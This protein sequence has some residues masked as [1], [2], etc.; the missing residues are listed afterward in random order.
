MSVVEAPVEMIEAVADLR[1]PPQADARLQLRKDRNTEG[2]LSEAEPVRA[3]GAGGAER[4]N[5][6]AEGPGVTPAGAGAVSPWSEVVQQVAERAGHRC[7]YC[8][9]H[10]SLQGA[11]FHPE[12]ITPRCHSGPSILENLALACPSCNLHKSC[13]TEVEDPESGASVPL[14]NP[15]T[16][17]WD[18]H[19]AWQG[20]RVV[21][22]TP[23]GRALVVAFDLNH[24]RRLR[25]RQAEGYFGLF[26]PG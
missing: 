22:K 15:R 21:G 23:G 19:F 6:V 26:P 10:Q 4:D 25:I 3:G 7:E 2:A 14:Y 24:P 20:Y 12:H 5:V 1:F 9:M 13:R 11:T 17:S 8:R 16:Q 18:N